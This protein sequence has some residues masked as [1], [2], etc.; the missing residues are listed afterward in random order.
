MQVTPS[1]TPTANVDLF[2][3]LLPTISFDLIPFFYPS[4][5]K[6]PDYLFGK[7]VMTKW[8]HAA[9]WSVEQLRNESF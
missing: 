3:T 7:E 1:W 6:V 5:E 2:K 8:R 4:T 9:S